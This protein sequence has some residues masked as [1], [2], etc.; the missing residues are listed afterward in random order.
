MQ[1][2]N[3]EN[4]EESLMS[5]GFS[6]W[7][8][9]CVFMGFWLWSMFVKGR[10]NFRNNLHVI[11]EGL[12]R[13]QEDIEKRQRENSIG[14]V[15]EVEDIGEFLRKFYEEGNKSFTRKMRTQKVGVDVWKMAFSSCEY[16][17]LAFF[18]YV[19]L[20]LVHAC[21]WFPG[22]LGKP[23]E[24]SKVPRPL[25]DGADGE[26]EGKETVENGENAEEMLMVEDKKTI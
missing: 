10:R 26:A 25:T 24:Q 1:E 22:Y 9:V 6:I 13:M 15:E 18:A 21:F 7:L 2:N 5:V 11:E 17:A 4:K 23:D 16:V 3:G 14:C 12:R 19:L 20:K 8:T